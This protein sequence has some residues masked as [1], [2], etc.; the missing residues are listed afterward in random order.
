MSQRSSGLSSARVV[1]VLGPTNTG[2]THLAVERMLAHASGM[3]GLPLRLLAREI[4]D[5]IVKARGP[6]AVALITGEEKIVP[7]RAT[8]FVCTVE[9]MPLGRA[10]EFLAVDE[11]QLAADPERGH[12]FTHRLLHAR[13]AYETMFLGAG[14]MAPLIRRLLPGVE[15]VTRERFSALTHEGSRKLTRLP[16]RSAVVA[17]SADDV[18]AIAELIRRQRGGAAVVMGSLSP[19]TRNAQVALYQSGE[20]DF[21]VATDAIG[22]GLNMDV[23]HVA[24]A[25]LSKFDGR[26]QRPLHPHEIGQIAGRA[27]RFRADGT[28]GVTGACEP[29]EPGLVG[30]VEGHSFAAVAAA[31]WRNADLDFSSL[32]AL[33][34]SLTAP[35]GVEGLKAAEEALDERALRALAQ[36][37]SIAARCAA[38]P[39]VLARLWDTCQT[40]DFR[41]TTPEEHIRLLRLLFDHLTT[42]R[43][44]IPD[45]W[46]AEQY[47]QLDRLHGEIDALSGRL[48]GVRT[49]AYVANRPDWLGDPAL[50]REATRAL[51]ERLSDT[52]H[53]KLMARFI[54][55]RTSALMRGLSR[56]EDLLAG[57]G[58]DGAVTVEGHF[59]GRL[60]GLRFEPARGSHV[61]EAKALRAAAQRAVGPE[62]GRRLG[63]LAAEPDEA[64]TLTPD[65]EVLWRGEA[66]GVL[67]GDQPFSPVVRLHGD[68][69][70][71]PVRARAARRLEAFVAAQASERLW[72]LKALEGAIGS[73]ALRGLA[74]GLAYRL[75]EAGG[76]LDRRV[77][78]A[79]VGRLSRGERRALRELGVRFGEFCLFLPS[80]AEEPARGLALAFALQAAPDWRPAAGAL[81]P[82]AGPMPPP[83]ALGLRGLMALG[84]VAAPAASLERLA[85]LL[86]AS[87]QGPT[88]R[89]TEAAREELGWTEADAGR[90]LRALDYAPVRRPRPGEAVLWRRRRR[91]SRDAPERAPPAHSPFAAL[92]TL[93][94]PARPEARRPG[95]A[96]RRRRPSGRLAAGD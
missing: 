3:I 84:A 29:M 34:A 36:E 11:I 38:D 14:T 25:G 60:R 52:L 41:K 63:R 40:P 77:V 91:P 72:A 79:E 47:R 81:T 28:F 93:Q 9:A 30:A 90:V 7:P 45:D 23:D 49:L 37:P 95:R 10:V 20:V 18:Y 15:I 33:A 78:E 12:L 70:A 16:R 4:Y 26:R 48:A 74:R 39:A 2:K 73:G 86:R 53:E 13:G 88:V 87:A 6:H 83:R 67:A 55:R 1:A 61:L 5:R 64:F 85:E 22:M 54:D 59:V 89:L 46:M 17:F 80:Q 58:A 66:A 27:G 19:R 71:A 50:W 42:G 65:G 68:L 21:L 76:V 94:S 62:L 24:F 75:V 8:Y 82:L 69:G 44:R 57:V 51:E 35:S 43:R 92:A 32:A 56:S 31:L 96:P